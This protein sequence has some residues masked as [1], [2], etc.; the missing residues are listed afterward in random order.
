MAV[1]IVSAGQ[2][3]HMRVGPRGGWWR[4]IRVLT[5]GLLAAAACTGADEGTL[6][7]NI[8]DPEGIQTPAG[9]VGY[10][11][12]VLTEKLPAMLEGTWYDSAI[13]TD[14]FEA[15]PVPL[16]G[17]GEFSDLDSRQEV[18]GF[19][20]ASY[21]SLNQL[22]GEARDARGFLKAY[23]SDSSP[24]LEGHMYA[25]EGY[26]AVLLADHFCSGIPL[27]TVD[28][29]GDYTL[30]PGSTTVEVYAH[31]VALFDAARGLFDSAVVLGHEDSTRLRHFAALGQG[32]ALLAL[33]RYAEAAAAVTAI[34]DNFVYH[35]VPVPAS[36]RFG[37]RYADQAELGLPSAADH[38][39]I[40]GLDYRSSGDPRTA[41]VVHTQDVVGNTIY[42]PAKYY[43][44]EGSFLY[45]LADGIEARLIEAEAALQADD[46]SGQWLALLNQVRQTGCPTIVPATTCP[47]SN[48]DDPGAA[49][50]GIDPR[51]VDLLFQE[52]AFWLYVTG[53]RQ[54]DM[55]RLVR[56]YFR[57]P[58]AVFPRGSYAGSGEYSREIVVPVPESERQ[59]NP[60]YTGC[61][62][63]NA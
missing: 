25:V 45:T 40:N 23:A 10:Y 46:E 16:G 49:G 20:E 12:G 2:P 57:D 1:Q 13:L 18:T 4:A 54:G 36:N 33:G 24:A 44:F 8:Q 9:A 63:G 53:H 39:G 28:F 47:L 62:N 52:R 48:L 19:A 51:R 6:P 5:V 15:L 42:V 27:S 61:I 22:R 50:P 31:A 14:E 35:V 21:G 17:V 32:R 29:Q 60:Q 38:E 59:L 30:A 58:G 26:A 43:P 55:R 3:T 41:T 56:Q 34:P 37:R 7:P 11:R